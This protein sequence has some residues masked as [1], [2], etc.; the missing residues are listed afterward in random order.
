MQKLCA[1]GRFN[2]GLFTIGLALFCAMVTAVSA[3]QSR[4]SS[5]ADFVRLIDGKTLTRPLIKLQVTP[6]GSI[7]GKGA[8]WAIT[9]NW[10]WKDGYFCRDLNWGGDD[11][12]YNCQAVSVRGN[13][14]RFQSDKGTG[15]YADFRLN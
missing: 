6:T 1:F 12:G 9:G 7:K 2:I 8:R 10:R 5:K 4:I 11:L 13:K 3:E 14:I 15:D